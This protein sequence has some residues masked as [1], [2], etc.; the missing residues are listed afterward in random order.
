MHA[1]EYAARPASVQST[2]S[3]ASRLEAGFGAPAHLA[4]GQVE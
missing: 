1:D 3:I 2:N 4:G